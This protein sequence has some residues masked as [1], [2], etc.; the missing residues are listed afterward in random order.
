M[1]SVG[2]ELKESQKKFTEFKQ[3][4]FENTNNIE[5][6]METISENIKK[7]EASNA[8]YQK[9]NENIFAEIQELKNSITKTTDDSSKDMMLLLKLSE[10]QS[11]MR[12]NSETKYGD[13]KIIE[14]MAYQTREISN[15]FETISG[16]VSKE[17]PMPVEVQQWAVG[18]IFDCADKWEIRFSDVFSILSNTI[19]RES[20]KELVK[21]QQIRDIYGIRGVDE[22]RKELNIS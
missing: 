22:I 5:Q 17:I 18:K 3:S 12:I 11:N 15:L 9:K 13:V 20:L 19:G 1:A 6:K 16:E 2:E 10:Y 8:E 14:K 4:M 7:Q 21:I